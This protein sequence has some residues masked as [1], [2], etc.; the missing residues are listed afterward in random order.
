M[1]NQHKRDIYRRRMFIVAIR[2][3]VFFIDNYWSL[4][5]LDFIVAENWSSRNFDLLKTYRRQFLKINK[6]GKL[7]RR[8]MFIVAN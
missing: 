3:K 1:Y 2:I 5:V 4:N 7:Y 8:Q 6:N